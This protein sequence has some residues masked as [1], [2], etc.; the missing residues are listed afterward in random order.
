M[1]RKLIITATCIAVLATSLLGFKGDHRQL[2][3]QSDVV[4]ISEI[5]PLVLPIVFVPERSNESQ[6]RKLNKEKL[7]PKP[8]TTATAS[9]LKG[10][11]REARWLAH[12]GGVT[13]DCYGCAT[14]RMKE[15]VKRIMII[16]F[17]SA[18]A[19]ATRTALCLA[20]AESGFNPGAIS[21]TDDWGTGQINEAEHKRGH[22]L[23]WRPHAGFKHAVLDPAYGVGIML[24]MSKRG[25]SWTPWTGTWGKG[26]CRF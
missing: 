1:A 17:K 25:T 15:L 16:R 4:S 13:G 22:P 12:N 2:D 11:V 21:D 24:S 5:R 19:L 3:A 20:D 7:R 6:K 9:P 23:W 18:G 10:L 14:A 8:K 26:M